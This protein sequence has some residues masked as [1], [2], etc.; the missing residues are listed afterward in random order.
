M[1]LLISKVYFQFYV[2]FMNSC[3]FIVFRLYFC[4]QNWA[5]IPGMALA[6]KLSH[7][8]KAANW[9]TFVVNSLRENQPVIADIFEVC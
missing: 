3:C 5:E 6:I 4:N 1:L 8:G 7:H 2:I 9:P